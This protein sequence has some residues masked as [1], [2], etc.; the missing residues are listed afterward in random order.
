[1]GLAD[2][3]IEK[4]HA[5]K[6]GVVELG[7]RLDRADRSRSGDGAEPQNHRLSPQAAESHQVPFRVLKLEIRG[8]AAGPDAPFLNGSSDIHLAYFREKW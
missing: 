4:V 8:R 6:P 2:K 3:D 1:M 7:E 5:I